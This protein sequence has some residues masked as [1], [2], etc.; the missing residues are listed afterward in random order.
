MVIVLVGPKKQ[1]FEIH[2]GLVCSRSDFFKAAFTGAF[3][4]AN[5]GTLTLPEHDPATFKYFVSWLYTGS[6]R[7]FYNSESINPT[8]KELTK[9]VRSEMRHQALSHADE[10]PLTNPHR[11][12]WENANYRDVPFA[13][14]I[15]LYILADALLIPHLKDASITALIEVYG[16]GSADKLGRKMYWVAQDYKRGLREG[17][18]MA[19]E[20]LPQESKLCQ[21][22]VHLFCDS[23]AGIG[24]ERDGGNLPLGFVTAMGNIFADRWLNNL[25]ATDWTKTGAI[26]SYHEHEGASCDLTEK[27]LEDRKAMAHD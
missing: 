23:S 24:N 15:A 6:L 9:N 20:S 2:K 8:L 11:K 22:I 3:K 4:E 25:P 17:L 19:W 7:G 14:L 13:L 10:L 18:D 26:C 21:V 27:Y 12:L 5:D 16:I 1:R